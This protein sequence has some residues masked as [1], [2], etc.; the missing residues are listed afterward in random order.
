MELPSAGGPEDSDSRR[1]QDEGRLRRLISVVRD[2]N[3]A[4]TVQDLDGRFEAWNRG[5]ERM[6][7]Y[8]EAEALHM[9]NSQL[10]PDSERIRALDLV[11]QIRTGK[12]VDSVELQ[13]TT[14][15]G[16][17][18]DVWLTITKL[19]G[20]DGR[21][22]GFAT[23]ERDITERKK[24]EIELHAAQD[25]EIV[26]LREV[27]AF[28]AQFM[29]T[30]AHE[31]NTPLTPVVLQLQILRTRAGRSAQDLHAFDVVARNLERL[32]RMIKTLV[33]S[34]GLQAGRLGFKM[35]RMDVGAVVAK[36]AESSRPSAEKAGIAL[37]LEVDPNV[38][39]QA[40]PRRIGQVLE[41]LL[42]NA[43]KFTPKGGRILVKAN[44][45]VEG[46]LVSVSD[47]GIGVPADGIARLFQ[48]FSQLVGGLDKGG[49]GLGL[50]ISRSIIETHGGTLWCMSPGADKG[51]TFQFVLHV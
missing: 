5:A 31:L 18:L 23:T 10:V 42:S 22:V 44:E 9:N 6:Y 14:K 17:T 24:A 38:F 8:S 12:P 27:D 50:Y 4:I 43:L 1:R 25:K 26:R 51:S 29:N 21:I 46:A 35:Q 30:I 28:R 3:D 13:R 2:S 45:T 15:D 20:D 47:T 39:V 7:G 49:V 19:L 37:D 16:R 32:Q 11:R 33:D 48:P 41:N 36:A 40:D 34:A